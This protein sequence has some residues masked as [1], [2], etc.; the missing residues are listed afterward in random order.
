MYILDS[1]LFFYVV[2]NDGPPWILS[3]EVLTFLTRTVYQVTCSQK[4]KEANQA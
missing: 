2:A 1:R 4:K 3:L